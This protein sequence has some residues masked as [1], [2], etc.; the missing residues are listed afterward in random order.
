MSIKLDKEEQELINSLESGEWESVEN[1]KD[2]IQT[3]QNIAKNTLKK[4]K[5]I[6]IRLSSNDLEALKTNAVELGLPYQTLV[7]SILHQYATGRLTQKV[8]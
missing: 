3:H 1:L 4:D 7:S 8:S 6:N 5:R 2:E